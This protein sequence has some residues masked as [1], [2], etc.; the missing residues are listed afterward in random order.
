MTDDHSPLRTA[1]LTFGIP[2][3][4]GIL[5]AVSGGPDSVAL[6]HALVQHAHRASPPM[7]LR[8]G[9]V[10]HG[11]R[12]AESATDEQFVR[13]VAEGF[14]L[15]IEV[16]TVP[17]AQY[18][19]ENKLSVET[20]A[21]ELRYRELRRMLSNWGGD[22]IAIGHTADDQ[23]ETV[24]M[25]LMRGAGLR[26]LGGISPRQKEVIRPFLTIRREEILDYLQR[27]E[28]GYRLDS[29]NLDTRHFRNL[30]RH[31]VM[32]VVERVSPG[33]SHR[34][35]R[36]SE[37]LRTDANYL[38]GETARALRLLDL[39]GGNGEVSVSAGAWR[40]LHS[41][42]RRSVLRSLAATVDP[43]A[44]DLAYE[45]VRE[46]ELLVVGA[47]G[48]S[49]NVARLSHGLHLRADRHRLCLAH[50]AGPPETRWAPVELTIPG[51]AAARPGRLS[52]RREE[53][54]DRTSL[55][56]ALAVCGAF[57]A[58]CDAGAV[59]EKLFMRP[60]L[61]GDR[62]RIVGRRGSRTVQNILVDG[63]V[64]SG[65]RNTLAVIADDHGPVWMPG[66]GLDARVAATPDSGAIVHLSF[67][68]EPTIY[69]AR[70]PEQF[71]LDSSLSASRQSGV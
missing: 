16:A 14:G 22:F 3:G 34:V 37:I 32:P 42:L 30:V 24:I 46:V 64:P 21:R 65:L 36:T 15:S 19:T 13:D 56:Q 53:M 9:H 17:T 43:E 71:S 35:L 61:A 60:R 52:A 25:R 45:A 63:C 1:L 69:H 5:V 70:M 6:L 67:E 7:A 57:H 18:A 2:S 11:L 54:N 10:N 68:P 23:T 55:E 44:T 8:V 40:A 38:D 49:V 58:L 31:T 12:G 4:A 48:S 20:A 41:S 29:S 62:L 33:S 26:G 47:Q 66:F 59:G 28:L 27:H 51:M 39:H 50:G